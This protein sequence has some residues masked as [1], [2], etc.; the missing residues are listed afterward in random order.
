MD[1]EDEL[2][3][4]QTTQSIPMQMSRAF[5]TLAG[6][7]DVYLSAVKEG[8]ETGDCIKQAGS[9]AYLPPKKEQ[10]AF[11]NVLEIGFLEGQG[12]VH[13]DDWA[14]A[15]IPLTLSYYERQSIGDMADD[16]FAQAGYLPAMGRVR[17]ALQSSRGGE[18]EMLIDEYFNAIPKDQINENIRGLV[19]RMLGVDQPLFGEIEQKDAEK[20]SALTMEVAQN[21]SRTDAVKAAQVDIHKMRVATPEELVAYGVVQDAAQAAQIIKDIYKVMCDEVQGIRG[22]MI[23]SQRFRGEMAKQIGYKTFDGY[24]KA[25][26]KLLEPSP[27]ADGAQVDGTV[28]EAP[29]HSLGAA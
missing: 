16:V 21:M 1:R 17:M 28:Q 8:C 23:K 12:P 27:V 3:L 15:Q 22:D 29:L 4:L 10:F 9:H 13:L 11:A 6:K 18:V 14:F 25:M 24:L 5:L 20:A 19:F 26:K 7:K 2:K